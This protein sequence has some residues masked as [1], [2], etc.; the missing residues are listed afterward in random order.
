MSLHIYNTLTREL[1]RFKP[2]KQDEVKVYYCGPTPYNYAHIGNLRNYLM[3]DIIVRSLRFLSYKVKTV[4]NL[5]DIDDKTIRDSQKSG[6]S[7]IEFTEFYSEAFLDDCAKL[8][9][10]PADT[11]API[12]TLIPDMGMIIDGL[13]KK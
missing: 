11:I 4:M 10:L 13:I 1:E 3:D 6:K 12:S 9:I 7:L 5:T 2:L 8:H